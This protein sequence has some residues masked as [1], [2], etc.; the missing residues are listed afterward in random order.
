M[1]PQPRRDTT[2]GQ[3]YNDLRNLA[4]RQG[5]ATDELFQLYLL[6][7]FLY[8]LAHSPASDQLILKGGT[9]LAAYQLRRATQDIDVQATSLAN[10]EAT[11]AGLVGEVCQ[12][13]VDDGV[14]FDLTGL[15][16]TTI[17]E[18][19]AYEGLRA[20]LP[21]ALGP[22]QLVLRIDANFGD[23]ITPGPATMAY[24][25]LLGGSFDIHGYPLATVLAEKLVTMLELA[26]ANTR[27]R[28]VGDVYRIIH[29][30]AIDGDDL[31]AAC[32]ATATYRQVR[33][34]PLSE[35]LTDLVQRRQVPWARWRTRTGLTDELPEAFGDAL[36][37][38]LAF[39]DRP[40]AGDAA[41][42][43]W[44]PATRQWET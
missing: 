27:D 10:D 31:Q 6:E 17:R 22:A 19:A 21:A 4:R 2:A 26:D 3:V 12:L 23:P 1:S 15:T 8:R 35:V 9:L 33:L 42:R 29:S 44:N 7:R 14:S 34:Q 36:T 43:R 38:V 5:R 39:A 11:L 16:V 37:A 18:G 28:D 32:H 13:E 30:H 40:L 20:R 24:P 25:Q 41:G